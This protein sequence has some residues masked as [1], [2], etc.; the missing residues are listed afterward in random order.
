[1]VEWAAAQPWSNGQVVIYGGSAGGFSA[2]ITLAL[3]PAHVVAAVL[4]YASIGSSE[5]WDNGVQ[6]SVGAI[7]GPAWELNRLY[8]PSV[9][10]PPE[11]IANALGRDVTDPACGAVQTAGSETS[12]S[13]PY[14]RARDAY[15][16]PAEASPTPIMWVGSFQDFN[17]REN[18]TLT[19][20]N[21]LT[22]P[23]WGFFG[24]WAHFTG[25]GKTFGG[26]IALSFID[27]W[28]RQTGFSLPQGAYIQDASG[29]WE[30][31]QA[32]PP[33]HEKAETTAIHPG[34]YTDDANNQSQTQPPL[35]PAAPISSG[36]GS[37]TVSPPLEKA[38]HLAGAVR[39]SAGVQVT[40]PVSL[41]AVVYDITPHGDA[42]FVARGADRV[43]A[44]G[45]SRFGLYP[46][47]WTFPAGD[48]VG[49][50]LAPADLYWFVPSNSGTTVT[51]TGGSWAL[52]VQCI[53]G[54]PY[55]NSELAGMTP[56]AEAPPFTV[57]PNTVTVDAVG[58]F[59]PSC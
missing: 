50:L 31:E 47:D 21:K 39:V 42:I 3:H 12:A 7:W 37:W 34:S 28:V 36:E 8:P 13:S 6:T 26:P 30:R 43:L 33:P 18:I 19:M 40:V 49:L 1:M 52:P 41:A 51:V 55:S 44:S 45:V 2:L 48:R 58:S 53:G 56:L 29:T 16:D 38:L 25:W 23:H 14:W 11:Y 59:R 22:G 57:S 15:I 46:Q 32:W 10:S 4:G 9:Y 27:H 54:A 5:A 20:F 35:G 17:A 24:Q